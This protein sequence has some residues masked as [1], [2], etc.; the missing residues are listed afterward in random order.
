MLIK[1]GKFYKVDHRRKGRFTIQISQT[2][3]EWVTG[4]IVEGET[5]AIIHENKIYEGEEVTV[6]RTFTSFTEVGP[7]S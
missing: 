6:R 1:V 7:S 3:D 5:N 2:S 4:V